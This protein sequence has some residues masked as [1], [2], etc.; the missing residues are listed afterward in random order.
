MTHPEMSESFCR[1]S[2]VVVMLLVA[3]TAAVAQVTKGSVSV[4][5]DSVL[6]AD[7]NQGCDKALKTLRDRLR[8]LFHYT[9]YRLGK[10]GES[11]TGV[12]QTGHFHLA[13][14]RAP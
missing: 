11:P 3:T 7:T 6:A 4:K 10:H 2:V 12:R 13:A 14:E 5:I 9:P 1:R 8:R